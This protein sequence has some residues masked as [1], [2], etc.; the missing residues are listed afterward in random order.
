MFE[1]YAV[2]VTDNVVRLS[3][4]MTTVTLNKKALL[5]AIQEVFK[6]EEIYGADL[7]S[8]SGLKEGVKVAL[9]ELRKEI[10]SPE[11]M[12]AMRHTLADLKAR[13]NLL[14]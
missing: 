7:L 5:R 4:N 13:G 11:S 1:D 10:I 14:I 9:E 3:T 8:E 6:P 2:E 12:A